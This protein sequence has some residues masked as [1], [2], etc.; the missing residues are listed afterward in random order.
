MQH[1]PAETVDSRKVGPDFSSYLELHRR[2]LLR[3]LD[4][5]DT[6]GVAFASRHS[7]IM[8]GLLTTMFPIALAGM[9]AS[10][11]AIPIVLGAVGGYGRGLLGFKSDLDLRLITD[12]APERLQPLAEALFYPLWNL[13]VSV[14]HQVTSVSEFVEG[15]R[16]DLPTAT[17]LLDLRVLSGDA[18]VARRLEERA[19]SGIFSEGELPAFMER[20]E[21]ELRARHSRFGDSVYLLEPDV[22]SGAGGLRDLDIAFWAARA[23]FR[24]ANVAGF[25]RLGVVSSREGADLAEATEFLWTLRNHL[26]RHANRRSDRLTFEEQETIA[27]LLDY[28]APLAPG[29]S[30][31]DVTGV[32]VE[33][34]MS[35]YYRH[36]RVILRVRE[37]IIA[38]S[39]P[40][41]VRARRRIEDVEGGLQSFNG[42]LTFAHTSELDRDP[43]LVL[44]ICAAAVDRRTTILPYARDHIV[45]AT[46]KPEFC[47]ALRQNTEAGALFVRLVATSQ[48]SAFRSNS[49]LS[50]LHDVGLL[51]AMIPEFLPVVGRVHHDIYHVYTVDVHSVAAVDHLRAL[52][53]GELAAV[54]PLAARVAA[55]VTRHHVL[56]LATLLHDVGKAIGGRDHSRRGADMARAI[57]TRLGLPPADVEAACHLILQHLVMYRV[58][59]CRDLEDPATIASFA[60]QVLGVEGLRHLYLLTIADLSTTS[61]TSMTRWKSRMLDE[62]FLSTEGILSGGAPSA[63]E[64]LRLLRAKVKKYWPEHED[65]AF[66]DEYLGSMPERYL[67]SN[68]P[69]EIA[70]HALVALRSRGSVVVVAIVPSRLE[71]VT[72]LCVV[73]GEGVS[74]GPWFLATGDRPGLL[75]AIAAAIAGNNLEV[76][77]AQ[78]YTREL[79]RG[80]EQAVDLFWVTRRPDEDGGAAVVAKLQRD[81]ESVLRGTVTPGDL[82]KKPGSSRWS[83]RPSP[84]VAT[85]VVLDNRASARHTLI[86]VVARDRPGLLFTVSR[87]F[88]EVGITIAIAK[89]NTEGTRAI[90]VFYVTELDG[91]KVDGEARTSGVRQHLLAALGPP[92]RAPGPLQRPS[93][94]VTL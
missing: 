7:K 73:T 32:A 41:L 60:P 9:S 80:G 18:S 43:A 68:A 38:R 89:I 71:D 76:H 25:R 37:Q 85:E 93:W 2:D 5:S 11:R 3:L 72:E 39:T 19:F 77:A 54:Q 12:E 44:R 84:P 10:F 81:L 56:L 13:G 86:E 62:L 90:D 64:R 47:E 92:G 15:A 48:E 16:R 87:A 59:V 1:G 30:E 57:L 42:Q 75:A 61:P 65:F 24:V 20:L 53:R 51:T 26:H 22:K 17:C 23:R 63:P 83:E 46:S 14:G 88:H 45:R 79:P 31:D 35:D 82:L 40:H 70:A 27:E 29:E 94:S 36:A 67:L 49:I 34:L 4:N 55:D 8:D 50:E 66:V 33:A 78:I 52:F 74:E 21:N 6:S 69:H 91:G 58:A 28:C